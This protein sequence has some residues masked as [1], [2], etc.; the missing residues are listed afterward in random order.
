M[1][2]N[3]QR[4]RWTGRDEQ[5]INDLPAAQRK[6]IQEERIRRSEDTYYRGGYRE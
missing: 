3:N 6:A 4:K 1:S 2:K 5:I